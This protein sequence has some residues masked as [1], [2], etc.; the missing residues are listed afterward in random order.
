MIKAKHIN[1]LA[2]GFFLVVIAIVFQQI[3]T[4]M[5]EQGIASGSPYDNA[6]SYPRAVAIIILGLLA[7]Q[8]ALSHIIL[9]WLRRRQGW[10]AAEAQPDTRETPLAAL[11]KPAILLVIFALYLGLLGWLGYHLTTAP[12]IMA[13]MLLCGVRSVKSVLVAG[14]GIATALAFLF[15]YFLKIVLPGGI[16]ALNI[17]W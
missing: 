8:Y 16:F 12:M 3:A 5:T 2:T 10:S 14:I 6:A 9:P 13:V 7:M 11:V 17:P 15:E 4:S 1:A